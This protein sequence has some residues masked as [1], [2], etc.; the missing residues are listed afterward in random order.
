MLELEDF[1]PLVQ[2]KK[3][4]KEEAE[5]EPVKELEERYRREL[6]KLQ[7]IMEERVKEAYKRGYEKGL[8]EGSLRTRKELE[9]EF[10]KKEKELKEELN[11]RI[12]ELSVSTSR[13]IKEFNEEKRK[14]LKAVE[15]ALISSLQELLEF[16]FINPE[17]SE[18][19][20]QKVK[21][22]KEEFGKEELV[23]I[24]AGKELFKAL[25]GEEVK[26]NP[27][28]SDNDFKLVFQDFSVEPNF[29][30]KLNLLREEIEREIK[31]DP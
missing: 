31:K 20:A 3:E 4:V 28:L 19:V 9:E 13:L 2:V 21:E 12:K 16:L 25:E 7:S 1:T 11:K 30:E 14:R 5:K 26:L 27:S 22:L 29:K 8:E 15:E 18:F 10:R 17:N 6:L 23:R 24:E